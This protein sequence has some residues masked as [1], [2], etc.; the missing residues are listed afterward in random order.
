[1]S[2]FFFLGHWEEGEGRETSNELYKIN[3]HLVSLEVG[4][5]V[6]W[7]AELYQQTLLDINFGINES[8]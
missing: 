4:W 6:G 7:L 8:N 2:C 5:L 1:M 3:K